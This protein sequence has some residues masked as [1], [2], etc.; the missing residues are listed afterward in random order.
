MN[1]I[2]IGNEMN[3]LIAE[4]MGGKWIRYH[5]ADYPD[6]DSGDGKVHALIILPKNFDFL[7]P[8][9]YVEDTGEC[10][11]DR[12]GWIPEYSSDF[13]AAWSAH[14]FIHDNWSFSQRNRYYNALTKVMHKR[15]GT[16][17]A[18]PDLL[19]FLEPSDICR[20]ALEVYL[21]EE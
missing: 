5:D 1:E 17:V 13:I 10:P 12:Y 9:K 15:L 14:K 20:A 4:M 11:R 7:C 2:P 3:A 16:M 18:W 19:G 6:P 8:P 21:K